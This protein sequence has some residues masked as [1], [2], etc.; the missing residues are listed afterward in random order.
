MESGRKPRL[1]STSGA[2]RYIVNMGDGK[3]LA[4]E[5]HSPYGM[6]VQAVRRA[7]SLQAL[8]AIIGTEG[9]RLKEV[10]PLLTYLSLS[11]EQVAS[12][13]GVSSRTLMR[14]KED[15]HIGPMASRALLELDKLARRG[16]EVFGHPDLFRQ[17]LQQPN[18]ALGDVTPMSL[19]LQPYGAELVAD[20]LEALAYGNMM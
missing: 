10:R 7:G 8:M 11:N 15:T 4:L 17:W 6:Y 1:K 18:T 20:A 2:D 19:L 14:W 5:T 16:L 3:T 13:L 12:L 9:L